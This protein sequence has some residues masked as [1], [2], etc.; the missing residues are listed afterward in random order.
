MLSGIN[1]S[2]RP[3]TGGGGT[4]DAAIVDVAVG[5]DDTTDAGN[6]GL[7]VIAPTFFLL[8][9]A[10]VVVVFVLVTTPKEEAE[11]DDNGGSGRL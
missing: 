2:G 9:L 5:D 10:V 4:R 3:S 6:V 8:R 1:I 11:D 7:G